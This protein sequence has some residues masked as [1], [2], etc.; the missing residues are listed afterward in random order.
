MKRVI[1]NLICTSLA[2]ILLSPFISAQE[3]DCSKNEILKK[4]NS[5]KIVS[6]G[7]INGRAKHLQIPDYP[8]SAKSIGVWGTVQVSVLIDPCGRVAEAK[9]TSGHPLLLAGSVTA[10]EKSLFGPVTLSNVPIWV[11]GVITYNYVPTEMNW[12][13]LGY[14]S[15]DAS[16]LIEFLPTDY[17]EERQLLIEAKDSESLNIENSLDHI[18]SQIEIRLKIDERN[19]WSFLLGKEIRRLEG[20]VWT[21]KHSQTFFTE[22]E[23]LITIAPYNT[24]DS[25]LKSLNKLTKLKDPQKI[26]KEIRS[27][28]VR[29]YNW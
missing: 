6:F 4:P 22:I 2:I 14:F 28:T 12:F 26:Q 15:N 27:I 18:V 13:G 7:V 19:S 25:L 8:L 5:Q 17:N 10:A 20:R 3:I 29:I 9:S 24:P 23:R 21:P 16:K 1:S 11:Y